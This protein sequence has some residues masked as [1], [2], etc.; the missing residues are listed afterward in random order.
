M[1]VAD[2]VKAAVERGREVVNDALI[3]AHS[4]LEEVT[5]AVANLQQEV[6]GHLDQVPP[7]ADTPQQPPTDAPQQ[8]QQ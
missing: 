7:S 4:A 8:P 5:A 3:K 1:A 2:D 6:Q